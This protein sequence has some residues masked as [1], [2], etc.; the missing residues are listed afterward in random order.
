MTFDQKIKSVVQR[1]KTVGLASF[2][3]GLRNGEM[4]TF[5]FENIKLSDAMSLV[6]GMFHQILATN[7]EK[8]PDMKPERTKIFD[9]MEAE[10]DR[11]IRVYNQKLKDLA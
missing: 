5:H 10:V 1:A 9:E 7:K 8:S 6:I 3:L 2:V 11:V 4:M